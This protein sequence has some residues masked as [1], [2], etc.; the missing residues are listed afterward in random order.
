MTGYFR[1]PGCEIRGLFGTQRAELELDDEIETHLCLLTERYVC[2]GMTEA[3]HAAR[4]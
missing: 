2:Q 3:A 4:R 1:P